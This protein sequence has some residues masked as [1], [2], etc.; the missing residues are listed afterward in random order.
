MP[1]V[2]IVDD[3]L[4]DRELIGG[5]LA[6]AGDMELTYAANGQ[7]ALAAMQSSEFDIVITDLVMPDVDGL[8]LIAESRKRGMSAPVLVVTAQGSEEMA[9]RALREGAASYVPKSLLAQDLVDAV[10]N[11]IESSAARLGRAEAY[12]AIESG[13]LV[14][15][16]PNDRTHFGSVVSFLQEILAAKGNWNETVRMQLGIAL[17]EALVNAAEHG[18]LELDSA[19][20]NQDRKAYFELAEQRRSQEP[21]STRRVD[22][23]TTIS[24]EEVRIVI[25]DHGSG[26]DPSTLPDPTDVQNLLKSS[27]RGIMLMRTFM[28]DVQFEEG[29]TRVVMIK[30]PPKVA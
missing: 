26:F 22:L 7:E 4:V 29:G 30:R 28:D 15:R 8:Q 23:V 21:F 9:F 6:E 16:L 13:E 14:F 17:E 10:E 1:R 18:N 12:A 5:L 19:L 3:V 11:V 27:G 20:R 24:E 25:T 2:L